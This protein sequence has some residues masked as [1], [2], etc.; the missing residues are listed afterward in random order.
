MR[1]SSASVQALSA[2]AVIAF[3]SNGLVAVLRG[4]LV[5]VEVEE[6]F[7]YRLSD[8]LVAAMAHNASRN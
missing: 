6:G 5:A 8:E 7:G 2:R 1:S 3:G 4:A